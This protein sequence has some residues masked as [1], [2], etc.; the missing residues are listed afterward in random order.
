[1]DALLYKSVLR[2]PAQGDLVPEHE[3]NEIAIR[4][5]CFNQ[6]ET[7]LLEAKFTRSYPF[8]QS[9]AAEMQHAITNEV[10]GQ[11]NWLPDPE[12]LS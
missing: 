11:I 9:D 2:T 3:P 10:P 6:A 5:A 12:K 8:E 1:M 4:N 7:G